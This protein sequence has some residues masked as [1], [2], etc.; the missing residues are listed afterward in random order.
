MKNLRIIGLCA[1]MLLGA[2]SQK[3]AYRPETGRHSFRTSE[4]SN[5][6]EEDSK[7]NRRM[8]S[9][10]SPTK[11]TDVSQVKTHYR[12]HPLRENLLALSRDEHQIVYE[13]YT[14]GQRY[15]VW[16]NKM[17]Q[18]IASESWDKMSQAQQDYL[19]ELKGD[20][21]PTVFEM[22][23]PAYQAFDDMFF[24]HRF[25]EG[26]TLFPNDI[27]G[28]LIGIPEDFNPGGNVLEYTELECQCNVR[29]DWCWWGMSCSGP[30]E[31]DTS[32]GCGG[33]WLK[34]CN[35]DCITDHS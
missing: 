34:G 15:V 18:I 13:S 33:F 32:I 19:L 29:Y 5:D 6:C 1:A 35:G 4:I 21:K 10:A 8:E 20:L 7:P 16:N 11:K 22:N 14:P 25:E 24:N 23:S 31:L 12:I 26:R 2:C 3:E 17:E 28:R 30:C 9:S 27:L